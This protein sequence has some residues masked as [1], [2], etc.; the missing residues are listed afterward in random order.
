MTVTVSIDFL[1]DRNCLLFI[2]ATSRAFLEIDFTILIG[3]I[4]TI[5]TVGTDGHQLQ[6]P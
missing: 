4:I 6:Q 5:G 1:G 2:P 3:G